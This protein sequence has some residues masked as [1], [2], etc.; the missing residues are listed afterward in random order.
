MRGLHT[1]GS[2]PG[3]SALLRT[4][5]S[6]GGEPCTWQ[7]LFQAFD[8]PYSSIWCSCIVAGSYCTHARKATCTGPQAITGHSS[9]AQYGTQS[10]SVTRRGFS[11]PQVQRPVY[12]PGAQGPSVF[13]QE[14]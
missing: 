10:V 5:G 12:E 6:K 9:T 2:R 3:P 1:S 11:P 8:C 14:A 4:H 13:M 7:K